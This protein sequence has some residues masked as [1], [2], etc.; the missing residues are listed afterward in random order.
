MAS[1]DAVTN[2]LKLRDANAQGLA[3]YQAPQFDAPTVGDVP[4]QGGGME[5]RSNGRTSGQQGGT[6]PRPSGPGGSK[7]GGLHADVQGYG[8]RLMQQFP[9]LRFTSGY[10]DP[11]HNRAV[12]GVPN[13]WHTK[14]RAI[15]FSGSAKDMANGAAWARSNGANEVLVHNVGSGQHLHAAW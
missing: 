8:T 11:A 14:G 4:M 2:L 9:G 3:P 1:S 13:S 12:G 6:G 15:D 7:W 10:R 5:W